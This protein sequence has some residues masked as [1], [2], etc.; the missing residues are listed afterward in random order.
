[1]W[2]V[3]YQVLTVVTSGISLLMGLYMLLLYRSTF[4]IK[5]IRYWATG[6]LMIGGG[7]LF[8]LV[9]PFGSFWTIVIPTIFTA[10]GLYLYLAGIWLFKGKKIRTWLIVGFPAIHLI[11]SI[12]FYQF[13]PSHSIRSIVYATILI[14]Y[15]MIAIYEMLV[16]ND[17][18]NH[19]R[20]LF[21]INAVAFF[22]FLIIL[23]LSIASMLTTPNFD[24]SNIDEF[25][26]IRV[27][28]S[29]F[30]M[31]VLTFGFMSAVNLQLQRQLERQLVSK[32]KFLKIIAHDLRGSVGTMSGFLNLLNNAPD[33]L[34]K[35]RN[36]YLAELEKLS[37]STFHLL[38]N[39]LEWSSGS[40]NTF[41]G[42]L[43]PIKLTRLVEEHIDHFVSLARFKSIDVDYDQGITAP[44]NG[45]RKM[46]ETV[47]RN[48][49]SNALKYTPEHGRIEI[50]TENQNDKVR[51][52]I[53]DSGVGIPPDKLKEIF[54]FEKSNSSLGTNG[55]VGSGF[56]LVVC[57]DFVRKNRGFIKINSRLNAGTEVIL[58]FPAIDVNNKAIDDG[59]QKLNYKKKWLTPEFSRNLGGKKTSIRS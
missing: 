40:N 19:L 14:I 41:Q 58:E 5:G 21:R 26:L 37:E 13:I 44:I 35:E 7:L 6:S 51:L 34:E 23:V 9:P 24:P 3:V 50:K 46:I 27:A 30:L 11:Q 25:A 10:T 16:L 55:E 18:Q 1:M 20:N 38:Q 57:H 28:I 59:A 29:G 52:L 45:D 12:V 36:H 39:L 33:I 54:T 4:G 17:E 53:K 49:F 32:N 47:V 2:E 22:I 15:C 56:G 8:K 31:T 43:E 42:D 48:L